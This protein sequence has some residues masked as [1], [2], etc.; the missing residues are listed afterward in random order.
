MAA[1]Y[2]QRAFLARRSYVTLAGKGS[3]SQEVADDANASEVIAR[4]DL[5][6]DR[7]FSI[8]DGRH[9][10]GD[11]DIAESRALG[12]RWAVLARDVVFQRPCSA[13]DVSLRNASR[14]RGASFSWQ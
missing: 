11:Q 10:V 9:D 12:L 13:F 8:D 6:S 14:T 3:V 5:D 2:V 7:R 4:S 1:L